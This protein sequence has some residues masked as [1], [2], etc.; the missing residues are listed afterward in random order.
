MTNRWRA[1][2]AG[3]LAAGAA[4]FAVTELVTAPGNRGPS[5]ITAVGSRFIDRFAFEDRHPLDVILRREH[6][7]AVRIDVQRR[8]G[9]G[10][11][12]PFG[13]RHDRYTAGQHR[14][15]HEMAKVMQTERTDVRGAGIR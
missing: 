12:E 7:D 14:G 4:A 1:A 8:G 5:L 2:T 10:V 9:A 3:T 11:T 13:D 6:R 15:G